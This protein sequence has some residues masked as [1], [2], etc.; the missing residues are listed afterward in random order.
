MSL[1]ERAWKKFT[2]ALTPGYLWGHLRTCF[3][4]ECRGGH[5]GE[6][7]LSLC[8]SWFLGVRQHPAVTCLPSS[9]NV[10]LSSSGGPS[11]AGPTGV[12][13]KPA[14]ALETINLMPPSRMPFLSLPFHPLPFPFLLSCFPP[15]S[16]PFF[17][18]VSCISC[19]L[20]AENDLKLMVLLPVAFQVLRL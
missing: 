7:P 9:S 14:D 15:S 8:L 17:N 11:E 10:D 2:F 16:L 1:R 20:V 3:S 6:T 12:P 19:W 13:N 18:K 5:V 4:L